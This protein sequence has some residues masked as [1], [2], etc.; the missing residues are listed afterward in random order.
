MAEAKEKSGGGFFS[1]SVQKR[2]SRAK[3]KLMQNLG[4]ADK[5]KDEKFEIYVNNFSKQQAAAGKLHKEVKKYMQALKVLEGAS[6]SLDET[7]AEV[8]EPEWVDHGT[9]AYACQS[10][11][12]LW[13]S[14]QSSL[15]DL[16]LEPLTKYQSMFAETRLK[17][18]KRERKRLDYDNA[19]HNYD[20]T[21]ASKKRDETKMQ[22]T[23]AQLT[24]A[25]VMYDEINTELHDFLPSLFES[26]MRSCV[27]L[28]QAIY[29]S[30][31]HFHDSIAQTSEQ[32]Y[33]AM[34]KLAAESSQGSYS[35][36]RL[37]PQ[38]SSY[39]PAS[40]LGVDL[41]MTNKSSHTDKSDMNG[42]PD[43]EQGAPLDITVEKNVNKDE[44]REKKAAEKQREKEKEKE[45]EREKR[46]E[47]ERVKEEEKRKTREKEQQLEMEAER[48]RQIEKEREEERKRERDEEQKRERE[49]EI[50]KENANAKDVQASK[51][52]IDA[53]KDVQD[54]NVVAAA[55]DTDADAP[56]G[57][58]L[59]K[60]H[61]THT[62][63]GE[64][65]D[66]L[67]FEAGETVYVVDHDDPEEQDDGW[68][69]GINKSN[70]RKGVFP[71]NFTKRI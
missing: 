50:E 56:P 54:E 21:Q 68:L 63:T 7:L 15:N 8:H 17:I 44:E 10:N 28:Y 47:K 57:G 12:F 59:Y 34:E 23:A 36:K 18:D 3:E 24:D 67:T 31:H 66:E 22:K 55:A 60:V 62:Y 16:V 1:K 32:L 48:T 27:E 43:D 6:K 45:R 70:C 33:N 37:Q 65:E 5:T 11:S 61:A 4:K 53:D 41:S 40:P 14:Y 2:A 69:M 39:V 29:K 38:S 25:K 46:K 49:K 35:P 58:Y 52:K 71:E 13:E 30:E 51:E 19:R 26:R 20:A 64:D 9:L 42:P